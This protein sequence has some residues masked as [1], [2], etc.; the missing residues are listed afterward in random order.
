MRIIFGKP[1]LGER[2]YATSSIFAMVV[3]FVPTNS[4]YVFYAALAF[5]LLLLAFGAGGRFPWRSQSLYIYV[6]CMCFFLML[7]LF[8]VMYFANAEDFKEL[9]KVFV[10]GTVI[11]FGVRLR[12]RDLEVLFSVF[13]VVNLL[14]SFLQYLG[15]YSFGVR[16]LT[17][18]YNTKHHIDNSLSY[19]SP[20]ALGLSA[21]PGQQSVLSLFLFSY[22]LVLYFFGGGGYKRIFLCV[23]A[24]FTMVLSQSKTALIAVGIGSAFVVL[25]FVAHASYKSKLV[26]VLFFAVVVVG[27]ILFKDQILFLFPEYVR[28][29]EQGGE[30]SSLQSRFENWQ[31]MLN[32]FFVENSFVLYLFGVGRSGLEHYGVNDLPYDSDYIYVLVNYGL[33]GL[34]FFVGVLGSFLMR[35]FLFFSSEGLYGKILMVTLIY[36]LISAVALNFFFEPRVLVLFAIIFYKYLTV[37][38]VG[39]V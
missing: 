31:Q 6:G 15:V 10:F 39:Y 2:A 28:L 5:G 13:V 35:G 27:A 9:L 16:E 32:V 23:F 3:L 36:A 8:R 12:G 20:R 4:F 26:A 19:S 1:F 37:R 17:D 33:V 29:S 18:L 25:L 21:G 11:F 14:V 38:E 24:L 7:S 34:A 30:I 22:F